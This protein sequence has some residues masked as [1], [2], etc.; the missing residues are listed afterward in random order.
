MHWASMVRKLGNQETFR[1]WSSYDV[2]QSTRYGKLLLLVKPLF[3]FS[4]RCF[5]YPLPLLKGLSIG[6]KSD[7][8]EQ[9]PVCLVVQP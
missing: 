2:T 1:D 4:I 5:S 7:R 6:L 9:E 3:F 8:I